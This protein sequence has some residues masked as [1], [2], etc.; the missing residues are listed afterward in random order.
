M[1]REYPAAPVVA[2]SALICE[3]ERILLIRRDGE[4]ARGQWS[5]PGGVLKLGET[6][7][8]GT[9]REVR[10][11]TGLM[12]EVG[13]TVE[14][15]ENIIRDREGRV[16][17]HY[18]LIDYWARPVAGKAQAASDASDVMWVKWEEANHYP[19]TDAT[20]SMLKRRK[21]DKPTW[22]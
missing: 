1:G 8:D 10:E 18:V 11:E 4:P 3:G 19:L 22:T 5:V 12:V 7:K 21:G 2:V 17:F 14:V 9:I 16:V 20:R 6:L 13:D 15:G